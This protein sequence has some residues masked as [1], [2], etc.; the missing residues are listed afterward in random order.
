M[1][2]GFTLILLFLV[3]A[4]SQSGDTFSIFPGEMTLRVA[5][6]TVD[7]QGSCGVLQNTELTLAIL[8]FFFLMY[9][10]AFEKAT[11]LI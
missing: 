7:S 1:F 3:L 10:F 6:S 11:F 8:F 2:Y 4:I 5:K 9:L